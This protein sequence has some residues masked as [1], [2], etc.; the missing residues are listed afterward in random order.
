MYEKQYRVMQTFEERAD[1]IVFLQKKTFPPI[2][3]EMELVHEGSRTGVQSNEI[4]R[5]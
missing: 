3:C 2:C 4:L 1:E 5:E